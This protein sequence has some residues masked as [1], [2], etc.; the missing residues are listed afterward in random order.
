MMTI[1]FING[2]EKL[3]YSCDSY[4]VKTG[5]DNTFDIEIIKGFGDK[6]QVEE[7]FICEDGGWKVAYV[8]NSAGKTIDKLGNE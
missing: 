1:T 4:Y 5:T 3:T 8:T 7:E 2:S 6:I